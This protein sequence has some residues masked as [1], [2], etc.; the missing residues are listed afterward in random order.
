MP[1]M[2][3]LEACRALRADP[4]TAQCTILMLTIGNDP[5][6]K[7]E[8]FTSGADDYIIKPFS[9]RNLV[10]RVHSAIRR[11]REDLR[12]NLPLEHQSAGDSTRVPSIAAAVPETRR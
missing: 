11:R 10:N 4:R 5:R 9:P 12:P 7:I 1:D 8:A 2:S 3:G 6:D